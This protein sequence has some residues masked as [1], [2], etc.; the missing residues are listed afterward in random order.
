MFSMLNAAQCMYAKDRHTMSNVSW[1]PDVVCVLLGTSS[2][3]PHPTQHKR[4]MFEMCG[5]LTSIWN[6]PKHKVHFHN[7]MWNNKFKYSFFVVPLTRCVPNSF[8]IHTRIQWNMLHDSFCVIFSVHSWIHAEA[9]E[10]DPFVPP[11]APHVVVV[12]LSCC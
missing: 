6:P 10:R 8:F 2:K 7:V 11:R 5:K 9:L 12:F 3:E 1:E 4:E